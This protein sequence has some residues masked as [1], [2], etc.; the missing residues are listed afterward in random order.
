MRITFSMRHK[1]IY[2]YIYTYEL[3]QIRAEQR[4]TEKII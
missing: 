1:N 3:M 2:I 4:G